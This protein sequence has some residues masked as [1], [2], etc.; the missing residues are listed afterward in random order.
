MKELSDEALTAL[1]KALLNEGVSPHAIAHKLDV[2]TVRLVELLG[3]EPTER[4]DAVLTGGYPSLVETGAPIEVDAQVQGVSVE[5]GRRP[6]WSVRVSAQSAV[7][8]VRA[9]APYLDARFD[10]QGEELIVREATH[11]PHE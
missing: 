4:P 1:I 5:I 8:T 11:S 2:S 6:R 3:R 10:M 7:P 9:R